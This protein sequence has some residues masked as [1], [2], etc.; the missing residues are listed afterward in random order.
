MLEV[1]V[2]AEEAKAANAVLK[3]AKTII[4]KV[5][6]KEE[7]AAAVASSSEFTSQDQRSRHLSM[8]G[9]SF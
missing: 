2:D 4:A 8:Q 6:V 5:T 7:L 3:I 1:V 9:T